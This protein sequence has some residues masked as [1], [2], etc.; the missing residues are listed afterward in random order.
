MLT[1]EMHH[2]R[3]I[4][5]RSLLIPKRHNRGQHLPSA[6][7]IYRRAEIVRWV[8][9]AGS[10]LAG[11][12]AV[13]QHVA[14][15]GIGG[16]VGLAGVEDGLVEDVVVA[17][18]GVGAAETGVVFEDGVGVEHFSV[19]KSAFWSKTMKLAQLTN[20]STSRLAWDSRATP[21]RT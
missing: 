12:F 3:P 1:K 8:R 7:V 16:P 15:D 19:E 9:R 21:A 14:G 2:K 13:G 10:Q 11:D 18:V 4:R 5:R 17:E 6:E 20:Q